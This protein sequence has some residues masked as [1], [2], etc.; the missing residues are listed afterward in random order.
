MRFITSL[1]SPMPRE[2]IAAVEYALNT[3]LRRACSAEPLDGDRIRSLIREAQ[4]SNVTLDRTTLEFQLRRK[5]EATAASF[6]AE[7]S[8]LV[9][10]QA[11]QNVL[12]V[13]SF[14]PFSVNL[15]AAQNHVYATRTGLFQR[16]RK[17][18]HRG[19]TRAQA[20]VDEFLM[21]C[22]QLCIHVE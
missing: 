13:A 10:L 17:K 2:F 8:S 22:K 20:W 15:W 18:A 16:T 14:M 9:K 5:I 21:L 7:P 19:D 3:L 11:L 6:A 12:R 1:G 4:A